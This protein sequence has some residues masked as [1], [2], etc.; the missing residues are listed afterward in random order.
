MGGGASGLSRGERDSM[1]LSL[2]GERAGREGNA[3]SDSKVLSARRDHI[4]YLSPVTDYL[5]TSYESPIN[6]L[7]IT[8]RQPSKSPPNSAH[9]KP[10][11]GRGLL[12]SAGK[13]RIIGK[14]GDT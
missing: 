4:D 9:H 14:E 6:K 12:S 7:P 8:C 3:A 2:L 13:N 10:M 1:E 11:E 5:S